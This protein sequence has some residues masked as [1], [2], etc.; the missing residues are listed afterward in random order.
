LPAGFIEPC[1]PTFSTTPS[2]QQWIHEI[3]RDSYRLIVRKPSNQNRQPNKSGR[4]R[5]TK[6]AL[7]R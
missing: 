3:K 2:G 5:G 4:L 6:P 1:N 7:S